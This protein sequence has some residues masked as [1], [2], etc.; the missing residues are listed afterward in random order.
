[1]N[2][3]KELLERLLRSAAGAAPGE[4]SAVPF[5][6]EARVL[7]A[8]RN[9]RA[10]SEWE[11]VARFFRWGLGFASALAVVIVAL[12]LHDIAREPADEL[13]LSNLS[14]NLALSR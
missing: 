14:V 5:G 7:A 10:A 8:W 11:A 1:M 13:A 12:S 6:V 3:N 4:A 2:A 9:T